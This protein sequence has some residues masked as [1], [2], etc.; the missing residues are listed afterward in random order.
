MGF[1]YTTD[2]AAQ[3]QGK[4]RTK[5]FP[6]P[7]RGL[8][9]NENLALTKPAGAYT[10]ENWFPTS[11]GLKSRGGTRLHATL[12]GSTAVNAVMAYQG[13]GT[14]KLFAANDSGIFDI[15]SPTTPTTVLTAE[16]GIGTSTSGLFSYIQFATSG[17]EFL[18]CVNGTNKHKVY[19]GSTWA[20]DSPAITGAGL[21]T[22]NWSQV[23]SYQNRVFGVIK[24][25]QNAAYLSAASIGGA[26][27]KFPLGGVFKLGGTLLFGATWSVDSGEGLDDLCVFV[28]SNGEVAAYSGS[29][30][31]SWTLQGVYKIG[32]PMGKNAWF[33]A[34]GDLVIATDEGL[35]P[36]SA[37]VRMDRAALKSSAASYNIEELWLSETTTRSAVA[38]QCATWP[39]KQL[40]L[41]ATPTYSG[42]PA[43]SLVANTRTGAWTVYTGGYDC[44]GA[45]ALGDQFFFGTSGPTVYEA[46]SSASDEGASYVCKVGGLFDELGA[47]AQQKTMHLARGIFQ[48]SYQTINPQFSVSVDYQTSFPSPPSTSPEPTGSSV[49]GT[50]T[51]GSSVWGGSSG[52]YRF[53]DWQSIEGIGSSISWQC[54]VTL[55][56][57]VDPDI[58]LAAVDLIFEAGDAVA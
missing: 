5:R 17:G 11:T 40:L 27:T 16:S 46:E 41:V 33:K 55:G 18:I 49:Y 19:D 22:E 28:S 29:D 2:N 44:R 15:T 56:N 50:G 21:T 52:R 39:Q 6:A 13:A 10:L 14:E 45:A 57:L 43:Q 25:S 1:F 24:N 34:G 58:E 9:R 30:P 8:I 42:L 53:V 37:A 32:R 7:V 35:V 47:T 12:D 20:E 38:W 51:W 54:Q 36:L 3:S 31:A 26:A 23:W 4:S 48:S